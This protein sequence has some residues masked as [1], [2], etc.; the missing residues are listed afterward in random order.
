MAGGAPSPQSQA[1]AQAAAAAEQVVTIDAEK[2]APSTVETF[3]TGFV[4]TDAVDEERDEADKIVE[5]AHV[6]ITFR[7]PTVLIQPGG[8]AILYGGTAR[9]TKLTPDMAI[10][11]G[12]E[13]VKEGE[14]V[15]ASMKEQPLKPVGLEIAGPGDVPAVA[16]AADAVSNITRPT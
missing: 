15:K 10:A 8:G 2:I 9:A 13:L 4:T 6:E 14:Q 16:A 7:E 1:L 3:R 11:I 5:S 12:Q